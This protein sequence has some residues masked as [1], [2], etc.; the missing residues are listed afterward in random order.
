VQILFKAAP[1]AL[2]RLNDRQARRSQFVD[3]A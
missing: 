1:L 2:A 3:Q